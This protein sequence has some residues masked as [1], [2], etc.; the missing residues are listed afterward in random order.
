[1]TEDSTYAGSSGAKRKAAVV[2]LIVCMLALVVLGTS[3]YFQDAEVGVNRYAV[4]GSGSIDPDPT[5]GFSIVLSEESPDGS[6]VDDG[7]GGLL[8]ESVVPGVSYGKEV[9]VQN[10]SQEDHSA[11]VRVHVKVTKAEE[12]RKLLNG[13]PVSSIFDGTVAA[14]WERELDN[15]EDPASGVA[16]PSMDADGALT[17]TYYWHEPVAQGAETDCLF[18]HVSIPKHIETA[19][20]QSIDGFQIIV[21]AEAVEAAGFETEPD[22]CQK[23]FW[24]LGQQA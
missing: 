19:G 9:S 14:G 8:Y 3:A 13:A 6:G 21:W 23:A 11:W 16:K 15:P 7:S 17:Y 24:L 10:T 5:D 22:T 18:T 20:M 1:M 12:W 2:A 4:S